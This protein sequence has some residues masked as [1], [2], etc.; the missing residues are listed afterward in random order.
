M[1]RA[2]SVPEKGF[3]S[4]SVLG[5]DFRQFLLRTTETLLHLMGH[6]MKLPVLWGVSQR[7]SS[8][9]NSP[10]PALRPV[11]GREKDERT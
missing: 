1:P 5:A 3:P 8:P 10:P 2:A 9:K 6:M 7:V 11:G 4:R